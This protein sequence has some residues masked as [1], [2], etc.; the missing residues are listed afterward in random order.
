MFAGIV[1][2]S[3]ALIAD[4]L[5]S[6]LDIVA[7]IAVWFGLKIAQ[8]PADK[9]H[10]YGHGNADNIAAIFVGLVLVITGGYI[11]Y[12]AFHAI[13]DKR[14][15]EPT[16][17]ATSA[18]VLTIVIKEILY[19]YTMRIGKKYRSPAVIANAYD[20]RSDVIV[21]AGALVGIILAQVG[22]PILDPLAGLWVAFFILK[23]ATKIMRENLPTLMVTSPGVSME[24]EIA[25][26]VSGLKGVIGV[27]WI[28]G[29]LVGASY[30]LDAAVC[31][32]SKI[33]V[34]E[35]HDIATDIKRAILESYPEVADI[36]IHIEPESERYQPPLH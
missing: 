3:Q 5:N 21:S 25:K 23:Q 17:I 6:L 31:V 4:S 32:S 11:G 24:S 18:A 35:G 19:R 16:Y 1:G 2:R 8:K 28:R 13:L 36:L 27:G 20:H 30:Y 15:S 29:R 10:P 34:Q 26:F 22:Y 7:N 33:T 12:E 14:F 9:E